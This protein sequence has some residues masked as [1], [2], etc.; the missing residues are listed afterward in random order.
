[1]D[2]MDNTPETPEVPPGLRPGGQV[3][4]AVLVQMLPQLIAQAV[5]QAA[6]QS[7]HLCA[8]CLSARLAWQVAHEKDIRAAFTAAAHAAGVPAETP[9]LDPVPFLPPELRPGNPQGA[10][11]L[12]HAVTTIGGTEVCPAHMPGVPGVTARKQLLI[13]SGALSP[14]AM[15]SFRV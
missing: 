5:G 10:P 7:R 14:S 9:G 15:A 6:G 4:L 11:D 8:H 12:Q 1:M 13:A 3:P 2:E